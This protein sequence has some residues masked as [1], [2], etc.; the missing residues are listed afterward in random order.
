MD[1][2]VRVPVQEREG[3]ARNGTGG[4]MG[5]TRQE[6]RQQEGG[7]KESGDMGTSGWMEREARKW[8]NRYAVLSGTTA[9]V[10]H[11]HSGE[12]SMVKQRLERVQG[13]R[14]A[15][16]E[17]ERVVKELGG[18][19]CEEEETGDGR[20]EY[21]EERWHFTVKGDC[22]AEKEEGKIRVWVEIREVGEVKTVRKGEMLLCKEGN[23]RMCS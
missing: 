7:R 21:D 1:R 3:D 5:E 8:G 13:L 23:R 18:E 15:V 17:V 20:I 12:C 22:W 19:E 4:K 16:G 2:D 10:R 6:K 9:D 11:V 14:R